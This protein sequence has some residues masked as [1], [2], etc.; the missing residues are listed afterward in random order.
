MPVYDVVQL[1]GT[2]SESWEK[3][4]AN[5]VEQASTS[6]RDVRVAEIVELDMQLDAKGKVEAYRAKVKLSFKYEGS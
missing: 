3:A 4:A 2:S 5:A 1:I 6:L